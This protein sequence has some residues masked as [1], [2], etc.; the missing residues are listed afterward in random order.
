MVKL[1]IELTAEQ[2]ERTAVLLSEH[3]HKEVSDI[4]AELQSQGQAE[5]DRIESENIEKGK[6]KVID[7]AAEAEEN[8][9][10]NI[11]DKPKEPAQRSGKG[12]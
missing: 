10:K 2:I 1:K 3:P 5:V 6:Q 7:E 12:G 8:K 4:I 11:K 9:L